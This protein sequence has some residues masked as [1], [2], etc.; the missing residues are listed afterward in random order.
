MRD[1]KSRRRVNLRVVDHVIVIEDEA[2]FHW[3]GRHGVDQGGQDG[4]RQWVSGEFSKARARSPT[5]GCKISRAA[6][7]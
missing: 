2:K 4:L 1:Q 5:P 7:T 6:I 3:G